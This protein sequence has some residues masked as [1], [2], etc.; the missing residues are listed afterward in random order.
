MKKIRH[1]IEYVL[2]LMLI[3]LAQLLKID[4][5]S[6]IF[7]KI[8]RF[9]GPIL[10]VS[11]V[12]RKNIK[13]VFASLNKEEVEQI[14]L[15][16]WDN[17]ARTVVELPNIFQLSDS[18]FNKRV[19]IEGQEY[20]DQV[21]K[22]GK[23][24]IFITGHFANWELISKL[25][26]DS[27]LKLSIIYRRA[28]NVLVD[29]IITDIRQ[30]LDILHIAKGRDG[31]KD[32]VRSLK[33]NRCLCLLVD[34]KLNNGIE[35]PFFGYPSM[36]SPAPAKLALDY[37]C[38]IIPVQAIRTGGANFVVKVHKP[39]EID[40][41][42]NNSKEIDRIMREINYIYEQWVNENPGQWFWLH[43][44]WSKGFYKKGE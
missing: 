33:S 10:P 20:L 6:N 4:A 26:S 11:N 32:I 15:Q 2:V 8:A 36:T 1:Y 18:E 25:G 39:I 13:R 12:A 17:L 31:V 27:G 29:K 23:S 30:R 37:K 38:P 19:K 42:Q 7:A 41:Q 9:I 3:K 22:S 21:Y 44:R 16:A 24:C 40:Y 28:N 5:A 35:V 34:Q 14:V 43:K